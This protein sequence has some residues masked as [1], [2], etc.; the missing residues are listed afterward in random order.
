MVAVDVHGEYAEQQ[1]YEGEKADQHRETLQEDRIGLGDGIAHG[2]TSAKTGGPESRAA[3]KKSDEYNGGIRGAEGAVG[4]VRRPCG[5]I[6][7]AGGATC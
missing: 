4:P 3:R 6:A 2:T 1:R 7:D 5:L